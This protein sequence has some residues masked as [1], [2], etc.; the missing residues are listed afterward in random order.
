MLKPVR[1]WSKV[2]VK[3]F[4]EFQV[5]RIC[6][7]LLCRSPIFDGGFCCE[8]GNT[9]TLNPVEE[10]YWSVF[11]SGMPVFQ[12]CYPCSADLGYIKNSEDCPIVLESLSVLRL[13]DGN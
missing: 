8:G 13:P 2:F 12:I 10:R 9:A 3:I 6:R 11:R 4:H 5:G 7:N 1:T